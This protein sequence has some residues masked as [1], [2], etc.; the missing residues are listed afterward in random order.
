MFFE[1]FIAILLN[2][3]FV[4]N[5]QYCLDKTGKPVD[6]WVIL[7]VPPTTGNSGYGY[8]DSQTSSGSF[9]Y[10]NTTVDLNVSSLT[11]TFAQININQLER[12]AWN[13]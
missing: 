6:W 5:S 3:I 8:Y 9:E 2:L 10:V 7:K 12:V 13:D 1:Y 4:S 11:Q